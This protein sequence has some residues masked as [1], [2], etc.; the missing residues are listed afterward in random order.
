MNFTEVLNSVVTYRI[1]ETAL[2]HTSFKHFRAK[3]K[4]GLRIL[5]AQVS[6]PSQWSITVEL[7]PRQTVATVTAFV[8]DTT[9]KAPQEESPDIK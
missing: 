3:V 6:P 7:N 9:T 4:N 1:H 5:G 2:I 8:K